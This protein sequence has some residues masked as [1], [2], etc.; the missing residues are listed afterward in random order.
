MTARRP[1]PVALGLALGW[2]AD[3]ALGDP[4]R[5]HPVAAFGSWAGWVEAR[6]PRHKRA[7]GVL[8]EVVV[9]AP[10][11]GLGL[12]AG[13]LPAPARVM[14]TAAL[15]WAALGGTSLGREG[16]AVHALL[17]AKDLPGARVQV[18]SLVGRR[19]RS[20]GRSS[21]APCSGLSGSSSTAAPTRSTRCTVTAPRATPASGGRPPASTTCSDGSRRASPCSPPPRP[22]HAAPAR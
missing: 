12:A 21:G 22:R 16:L 20:S 13:R 17:D 15:T 2:V 5:G 18:R 6:T 9:L 19:T 7:A 14:A 11:V 8:T 10:V 1:D 4:Q 3:R